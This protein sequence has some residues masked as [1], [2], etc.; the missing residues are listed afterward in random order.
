MKKSL[1][2]GICFLAISCNNLSIPSDGESLAIKL[3]HTEWSSTDFLKKKYICFSQDQVKL[4]AGS[5]LGAEASYFTILYQDSSY[6]I[7]RIYEDKTPAF[8][9]VVQVD[10]QTIKMLLWQHNLNV[11]S[12]EELTKMILEKGTVFKL[13]KKI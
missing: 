4:K 3:Q 12:I 9:G 8:F 11:A 2:L 6:A 10:Q 13:R 5:V 7:Y 1:I